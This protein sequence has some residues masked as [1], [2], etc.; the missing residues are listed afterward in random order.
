MRLAA[1][2]L[3]EHDEALGDGER[4]MRPMIFRNQRERQIDARSHAG[5]CDELPIAQIDAVEVDVRLRKLR[6]QL[7][8]VM[9]MRR[10][11]ALVEQARVTEREC[12]SADRTVA[13]ALRGDVR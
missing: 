5:R 11:V 13:A 12:A 8:S 6:C 2:P 1:L 9:P 3:R 10:D 7:R 4:R